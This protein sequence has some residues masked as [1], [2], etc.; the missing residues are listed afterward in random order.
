M[1]VKKSSST[2]T[3]VIRDDG[4][5]CMIAKVKSGYEVYVAGRFTGY[6]FRSMKRLSSIAS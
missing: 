5:E 6:K 4:I 1:T 3:F 2:I